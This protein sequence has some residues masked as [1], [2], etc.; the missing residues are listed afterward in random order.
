MRRT[1]EQDDLIYD[2]YVEIFNFRKDML[3][4]QVIVIHLEQRGDA[5]KQYKSVFRSAWSKLSET[6]FLFV[7]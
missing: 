3:N 2:I 5:T 7:H 4:L 6:L 1:Q